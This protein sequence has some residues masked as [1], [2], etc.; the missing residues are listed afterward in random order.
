VKPVN[1]GRLAA[2]ILRLRDKAKA[3][4]KEADEQLKELLKHAK[5][6]ERIAVPGGRVV[7]VVDNYAEDNIAWKACAL[8]RFDLKPAR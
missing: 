4:W 1:V 7:E 2:K 3:Q 5:P 6:G 8:H